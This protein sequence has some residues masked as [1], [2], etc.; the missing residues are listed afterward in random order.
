MIVIRSLMPDDLALVCSAAPGVFDDA[1]RRELTA[2]FL[3]DPR[4]HLVAALEGNT[5]IGFVSA[6][7][8][9]HPDKPAELWI[10]EVAV[11]PSHQSRG[12]GRKMLEAM[13]KLGGGLGCQC[14]WVL[15]DSANTAAM[16]LYASAGGVPEAKPTVLFEFPLEDKTPRET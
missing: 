2:E 10:N 6:V 9:V 7:H 13:L 8:Y 4:H 12:V 16:R 15:T 1:P 14:A 11:A 3:G 5:M